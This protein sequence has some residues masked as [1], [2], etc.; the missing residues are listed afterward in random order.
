V[1][2]VRTGAA[3]FAAFSLRCP[4]QG[5]TVN[6]QGGAFACPAH[7]ARFNSSGTWTGGQRTS[8]LTALPATYNAASGTVVVTR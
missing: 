4:H 2:L 3:S 8:N 7:G 6:V 1:A 5:F